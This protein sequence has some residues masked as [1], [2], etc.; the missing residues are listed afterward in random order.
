MPAA[1][2]VRAGTLV[3]LVLLRHPM[4]VH[5]QLVDVVLLNHYHSS[6]KM[7]RLYLLLLHGVSLLL[8]SPLQLLHVFLELL[9]Q[10]LEGAILAKVREVNHVHLQC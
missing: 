1:L 2:V 8:M 6:S 7:L 9:A 5:D 10:L 3:V 4:R